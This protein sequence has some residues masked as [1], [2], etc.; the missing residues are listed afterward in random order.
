MSFF[1]TTHK[2]AW[3]LE[4]EFEVS[5]AARMEDPVQAAEPCFFAT[6]QE[7]YDALRALHTSF[8]DRSGVFNWPVCIPIDQ[9][10]DTLTTARQRHDTLRREVEGFECELCGVAID[11]DEGPLCAECAESDD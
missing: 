1:L 5:P 7:A 6:E 4:L 2:L 9:P 3:C 11:E 10:Y 8:G